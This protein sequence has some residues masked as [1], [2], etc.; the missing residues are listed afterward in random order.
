MLG[1]SDRDYKVALM[2]IHNK[3]SCTLNELESSMCS[4]EG[5]E[6]HTYVMDDEFSVRGDINDVGDDGFSYSDVAITPRALTYEEHGR[7]H[8]TRLD[9]QTKSFLSPQTQRLHQISKT[10]VLKGFVCQLWLLSIN[11]ERICWRT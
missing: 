2:V 8:L 7:S 10:I 1:T 4:Y 3:N 9:K 5:E 11:P 6:L